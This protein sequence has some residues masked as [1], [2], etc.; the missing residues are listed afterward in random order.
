M[1]QVNRILAVALVCAAAAGCSSAVGQEEPDVGAEDGAVILDAADA[2]APQPDLLV[3]DTANPEAKLSFPETIPPPPDHGLPDAADAKGPVCSSHAGCPSGQYCS[4]GVCKPGCD[5]LT[6][7]G[8]PGSCSSVCGG[9]QVPQ[10]CRH[11]HTCL[12]LWSTLPGTA[13]TTNSSSCLAG[14]ASF[15]LAGDR[16]ESLS[17]PAKGVSSASFR[18]QTTLAQ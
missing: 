4:A 2:G 13:N 10:V 5:P 8:G 12:C 1:K 3:P 9:L 18:V 17:P 11:D 7:P 14:S 16:L 15:C 6:A